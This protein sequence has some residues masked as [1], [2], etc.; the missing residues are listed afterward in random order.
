MMNIESILS[1]YG[2]LKTHE[3]VH[4]MYEL[5]TNSDN[6]FYFTDYNNG[7]FSLSV[8]GFQIA[9]RYKCENELQ[10]R[11]IIENCGYYDKI[12]KYTREKV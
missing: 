4:T 6:T 5:I 11:F 9:L 2:F 1:D 3:S 12:K 10:L 7:Q 8:D